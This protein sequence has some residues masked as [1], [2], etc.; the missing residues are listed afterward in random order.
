[1]IDVEKTREL[2]TPG[3]GKNGFDFKSPTGLPIAWLK[4]SYNTDVL[5]GMAV[6]FHGSTDVQSVGD[7][8][9]GVGLFM[10]EVSLA[11]DDVTLKCMASTASWG[12]GS[13]RQFQLQTRNGIDW[14]PGFVTDV[15]TGF[16]EDN[17]RNRVLMGIFGH[18]NVDYFLNSLGLWVNKR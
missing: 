18:L 13:V 2:G 14:S 11:V 8:R 3:S 4:F 6:R 17:C 9:D 10:S 12:R 1:M 16:T 15:P 5:K 7:M